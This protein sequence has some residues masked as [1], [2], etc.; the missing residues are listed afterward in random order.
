M[1]SN[2]Q[3]FN[4]NYQ[5]FARDA[6][7]IIYKIYKISLATRAGVFEREFHKWCQVIAAEGGRIYK[8]YKI[9]RGVT[10]SRRIW[11]S[12][13]GDG[14]SRGHSPRAVSRAACIAWISSRYLAAARNSISLAA[15]C[16]L[17]CASRMSLRSCAL[18]RVSI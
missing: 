10:P 2:Y 18:L 13:E 15:S 8:I 17:R 4:S 3:Q 7:G 9:S 16:I 5:Q 6:S 12:P 11:C 14:G 1:N